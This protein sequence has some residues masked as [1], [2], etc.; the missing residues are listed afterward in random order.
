[1]FRIAKPECFVLVS[2][3]R[4]EAREVRKTISP[5]STEMRAGR[6]AECR[7]VHPAHHG[8]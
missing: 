6:E 5:R 8:A 4:V 3:N 1:M 2:P 7:R